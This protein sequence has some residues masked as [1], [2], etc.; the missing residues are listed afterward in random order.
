VKATL[1]LVLLVALVSGCTRQERPFDVVEA[2]VSDVHAAYADG[3]LAAVALTQTSR[4][5]FAFW[6]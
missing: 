2:T 1:V 4:T 6:T 3:S 5:R